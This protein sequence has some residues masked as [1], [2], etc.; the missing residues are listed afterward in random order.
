MDYIVLHGS[1]KKTFNEMVR[2]GYLA[3]PLRGMLLILLSVCLSVC[4]FACLIRWLH[5]YSMHCI[6]CIGPAGLLHVIYLAE[7]VP[8]PF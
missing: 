5:T 8:D 6:V 2:K 3:V 4:L 7:Y 1:V